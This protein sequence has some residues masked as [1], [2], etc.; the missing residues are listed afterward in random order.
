M[1]SLTKARNFLLKLLGFSGKSIFYIGGNDVLPPPLERD[2]EMR[3]L[4]EYAKGSMD[5]RAVLI[6]HNLRLVV[7][8]AKKFENAG[9]NV[10]DLISIGT[11]GLIKAVNT[12][13]IDKNIKLATY[14]SRCIENEILMY[15][16]RDVKRKSEVSLDEPLN[17]DWDGN[18]LLLSDIL[19]TENDVVSTRLEEEVN[20]KLLYHALTKLSD[21]EKQIMDMRFGLKTGREMTQKEVAD[22]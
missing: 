10:E 6:E 11:I 16:R 5:A 7:Y 21:R 4:E 9:V 17:V 2:E 8:I 20:R 19:G 3:M 1:L 12:F 22:A 14:A 13:K 18:E 15:L